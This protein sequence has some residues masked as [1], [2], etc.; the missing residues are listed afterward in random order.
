MTRQ[1]LGAWLALIGVANLVLAAVGWWYC[2]CLG[3]DLLGGVYTCDELAQ[4]GGFNIPGPDAYTGIW[5]ECWSL[6][7]PLT[8]RA[9]GSVGVY[10]AY[11]LALNGIVLAVL[12]SIAAYRKSPASESVH[13]AGA[14]P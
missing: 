2:L 1:G 10:S 14:A 4:Q 5:Y 12:G 7:D 8:R 6:C 3:F 11:L 13:P 9:T